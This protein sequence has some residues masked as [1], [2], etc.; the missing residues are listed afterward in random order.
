MGGTSCKDISLRLSSSKQT[1]HLPLVWKLYHDQYGMIKFRRTEKEEAKKLSGPMTI[2]ATVPRRVL[3]DK[4]KLSKLTD[5]INREGGN[6]LSARGRMFSIDSG[7]GSV[8]ELG[9]ILDSFGCQWD[10]Q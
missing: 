2:D 6:V 3:D 8:D 9:D 1:K 4:V 5:A 7:D 10:I